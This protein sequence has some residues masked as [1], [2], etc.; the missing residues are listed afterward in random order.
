[1]KRYRVAIVEPSAIVAEGVGVLLRASGDI[2]VSATYASPA[3]LQR[4]RSQD[5]DVVVASLS[6]VRDIEL[7]RLGGDTPV[8]GIR[9]VSRCRH[10]QT[11][12][13]RC[14]PLQHRFGAS[15]EHS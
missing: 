10:P 12:H 4:L 7:L 2:D 15:A 11:L 1:M 8:V 6:F 5:V 3:E 13:S 14:K 9:L